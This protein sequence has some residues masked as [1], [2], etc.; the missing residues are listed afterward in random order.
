MTFVK[1]KIKPVI[2]SVASAVTM[3]IAPSTASAFNTSYYTQTSK[4]STGK[5]V[6]VKVTEEGIHQISYDQLRSWGF[7]DPSSVRVYGYG[8]CSLTD[9]TYNSKLVDDLP[10]V[11]IVHTDDSRLLFYGEGDVRAY[12]NS[13]IDV[14][15]KRNYYATAGY[16]LLTDAPATDQI[17]DIAVNSTLSRSVY[18]THISTALIEDEAQAPGTG[19]V[20]FHGPKLTPGDVTDCVF[21]IED[22]SPTT[23][24]KYGIFRYEFA[25]KCESSVYMNAA[26]PSGI[27][28]VASQNVR[29]TFVLQSSKLYKKGYGYINFNAPT[30][31]K[32]EDGDYNFAV[33]LPTS[34]KPSYVAMDHAWIA[35]PRLNNMANHSQLI[36]QFPGGSSG[37]SS[38]DNFSIAGA[39][40][41][42]KVFNIS[43]SSNVFT[44]EISYNPATGT[45]IGSFDKT[46]STISA[47]T[48][49]RL[50]A[51]DPTATDFAGVEYAG[52]IANQNIHGDAT[53]TMVIVTNKK[54]YDRAV[55]LAEAHKKYDGIDVNVYTQDQVFNE[56][57][58]GTPATMGIRRMVKMF[59]DRGASTF[60]YLLLYGP[61]TWDNRHITVADN[62]QVLTHQAQI[63][64]YALDGITAYCHDAYFGMVDDDYAPSSIM[65]APARVAVGR[66]PVSDDKE[67]GQV[68]RKCIKHMSSLPK[69]TK[70]PTGIFLRD[71]GNANIHL[72]QSEEVI[73]LMKQKRPEMNFV[74]AHNL[75]YPWVKKEAAVA[76]QVIIDALTAGSGYFCY[77]GHGNSAGFTAEKL[78][79]TSYVKNTDYDTYPLAMLATCDSYGFDVEDDNIAKE[80]II[81]ENG[82]MI[83]VVGSGRTVYLEYNHT[84]N[85]AM[86]TA[87]GAATATSTVGDI[88]AAG[89]NAAVADASDKD[90]AVNTLDFNLCGDP[91]LKLFAPAKSIALTTVNGQSL[92]SDESELITINPIA[93]VPVSG[94]IKNTDGSVDTSFNGDIEIRIFEDAYTVQTTIKNSSDSSDGTV[95]VTL[96]QDV[97]ASTVAH[98]VNGEFATNITTP[99]PLRSG[100]AN[101]VM[102]TAVTD[103]GKTTALGVCYQIAVNGDKQEDIADVA[104][105]E[106]TEFY[107]DNDSFQDGET[108][109]GEFRVIAT[110][111]VPELGINTASAIGSSARLILDGNTS[112]SAASKA[113][114]LDADGTA[115]LNYIISNIPDGQHTLSLAVSDNA[116]NLAQRSISFTVI[117]HNATIAIVTDD[118]T[119]RD[120]VVIDVEHTFSE[121]PS[122]RLVIVDKD[123][124]T[125]FTRQDVSFPYTWDLKATDGSAVADGYYDAYVIANASG[126][127]ASSTP[128]RITVIR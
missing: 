14:D 90:H 8:G 16:Y 79:N 43:N 88:Y 91:A 52:D 83:G 60:K 80:M 30:D 54:F 74:R 23:T 7:S 26:C 38:G 57:S 9:D 85:K 12:A 4:L 59:Y 21:R 78:W 81:K 35:Y 44:H 109:D 126:T 20:F 95:D 86:A 122:T 42:V 56:F 117:N 63:E 71:A 46:Y 31:S 93:K 3:M 75:V 67:A 119:A 17:Q 111:T 89:R 53:P 125:V 49:C 55:E 48:T 127:Y 36:M 68:N 51:F 100:D 32:I 64:D 82:G 115:S 128:A 47:I 99:Y 94:V 70:Y 5:W 61:G 108:V 106:I 123:Q 19:G 97:L 41:N 6:K 118:K 114:T 121:E 112:Y 87:Y 45:A 40:A 104:G 120:K 73:S 105:P 107:I 1:R 113:L 50:I 58:S 72:T 102:L 92:P 2:V 110:I 13:Y 76:R 24:W 66:I 69:A 28:S 37:I 98:V 96:D 62:D 65:F 25:A 103:D 11:P 101:R 39:P 77:A 29:A 34:P 10:A 124:N 116:G 18:N 22:F 84:L 33:T 27:N 15:V